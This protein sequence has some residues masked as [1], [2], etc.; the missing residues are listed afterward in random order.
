MRRQENAQ[1]IIL[2]QHQLEHRRSNGGALHVTSSSKALRYHLKLS[3]E[4]IKKNKKGF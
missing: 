2:S 3:T 4:R 1:V